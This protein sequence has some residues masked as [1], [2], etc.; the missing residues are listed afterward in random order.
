MKPKKNDH[1]E[2]L[3]MTAKNESH[4]NT[5]Y[6][7]SAFVR[8]YMYIKRV[9]SFRWCCYCHSGLDLFRFFAA[10]VLWNI[11]LL[12][13]SDGNKL[14]EGHPTLIAALI[15]AGF[16]MLLPLLLPLLFMSLLFVCE[17]LA[18]FA[19]VCACVLCVRIW[20]SLS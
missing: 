16:N 15:V 8:V 14:S 1:C 12:C 5:H 18:V 11:L 4:T 19:I 7:D 6:T 2:K 20:L 13:E 3:M 17:F 10:F 9:I